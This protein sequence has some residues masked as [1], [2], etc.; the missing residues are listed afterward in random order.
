MGGSICF[1]F[2]FLFCFVLFFFCLFV[3]FFKK[4][5]F[6]FIKAFDREDYTDKHQRTSFNKGV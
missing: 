1:L 3:V 5:T 4:K 2:V 6:Q